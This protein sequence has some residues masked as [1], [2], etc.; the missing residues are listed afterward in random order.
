VQHRNQKH[1]A[2]A[3]FSSEAHHTFRDFHSHG[4]PLSLVPLPHN[5]NHFIAVSIAI[6]DS[7]EHANP[8]GGM[9]PRDDKSRSTTQYLPANIS[10]A[11]RQAETTARNVFG[12]TRQLSGFTVR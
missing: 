8:G 5:R 2:T 9:Q 7:K 11:P 4:H 12:E 1:S 3:T 10:R 6:V